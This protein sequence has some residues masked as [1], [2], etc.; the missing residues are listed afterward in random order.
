MTGKHWWMVAS[1]ISMIVSIVLMLMSEPDPARPEM[2]ATQI[3]MMPGMGSDEQAIMAEVMS[4][5]TGQKAPDEDQP[6]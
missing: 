4:N 5:F 6:E 1:M 2:G 3:Q